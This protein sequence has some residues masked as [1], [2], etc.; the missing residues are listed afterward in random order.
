MSKIKHGNKYKNYKNIKK[1]DDDRMDISTQ[2]MSTKLIGL[3]Y[4]MSASYMPVPVNCCW[5]DWLMYYWHLLCTYLNGWSQNPLSVNCTTV[6]NKPQFRYLDTIRDSSIPTFILLSHVT[7]PLWW[8]S[9][10]SNLSNNKQ[11]PFKWIRL[12]NISW[13]VWPWCK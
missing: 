7:L 11:P 2:N 12:E 1:Y 4:M 6:K 9:N 8:N 3:T 10:L 13:R 5:I